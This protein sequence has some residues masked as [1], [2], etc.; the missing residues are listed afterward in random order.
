MDDFSFYKP[1]SELLFCDKP[2]LISVTANIR[3]MMMLSDSHY[4]VTI[5]CD[6]FTAAPVVVLCSIFHYFR[7]AH[8]VTIATAFSCWFCDP[9]EFIDPDVFAFV[10]VAI[11]V[12]GVPKYFV[13]LFECVTHSA[14]GIE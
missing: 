8:R 6:T 14:V 9:S 3:K 10:E 12:D 2:V 13:T 4:H 7:I 5:R 1:P 11:A